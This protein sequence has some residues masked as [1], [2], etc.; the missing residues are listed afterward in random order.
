M[1]LND[2]KVPLHFENRITL[3]EWKSERPGKEKVDNS[4]IE[5]NQGGRDGEAKGAQSTSVPGTNT[6]SE[7]GGTRAGSVSPIETGQRGTQSGGGA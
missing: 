3:P 2:K 6:Q 5:N 7:S 1:V 4:L